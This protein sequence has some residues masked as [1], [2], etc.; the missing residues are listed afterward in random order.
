MKHLPIHSP[1][2]IRA[3]DGFSGWLQTLGY[4]PSSVYGLPNMVREFLW[5]GEAQGLQRADQL[6]AALVHTFF[7]WLLKRS[8]HRRGGGLSITHITKYR[9]ALRL[10]ARFLVHTRGPS[11]AGVGFA[12]EITLTKPSPRVPTVLSLE[13]IRALYAASG[14][15]GLAA[16]DRAMLAVFYGCGLRRAE[17]LRLNREH[18]DWGKRLVLVQG[19]PGRDGAHRQRLVPMTGRVAEDLQ[20]W[21]GV[22]THNPVFV[23]GQGRRLTSQTLAMRLK[24]LAQK[25]GIVACPAGAP[26]SL[27]GLRHAIA[28]HLLAAGMRLEDIR[29]FLGHRS[30]EATQIY[31][32]IATVLDCEPIMN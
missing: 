27:H 8:N 7:T 31:T 23:S 30:L 16:R 12:V 19:K 4:A 29:R 18:L 11:G 14:D 9:Q 3:L 20:A 26:V 24:S 5:L 25:A 1:D 21:L 22:H 13:Q 2:F 32:H 17:G 6:D 10:F 15:D 28:T